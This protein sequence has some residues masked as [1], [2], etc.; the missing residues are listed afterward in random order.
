MNEV[1]SVCG[2]VDSMKGFRFQ[3]DVLHMGNLEWI[4]NNC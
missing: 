1:H 3:L 4:G 2:F